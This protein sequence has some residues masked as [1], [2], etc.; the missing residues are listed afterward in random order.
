MSK[1]TTTTDHEV[2][3]RWVEDRGGRPARVRTGA[4]QGG[5]LRIDFQEPEEEFEEIPWESFFEIFD[6]NRLAF[7][8]QDTTSEGGTSRFNKFVDRE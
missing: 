8:H 2:I 7:L 1:A 6:Q 5:L 3:R 4:G